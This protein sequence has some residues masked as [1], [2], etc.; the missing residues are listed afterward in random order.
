M[1]DMIGLARQDVSGLIMTSTNPDGR[2]WRSGQP[3]LPVPG[4]WAFG[5]GYRNVTM[6]TAQNQSGKILAR[7]VT[8][9]TPFTVGPNMVVGRGLVVAETPAVVIA[10]TVGQPCRRA[11]PALLGDAAVPAIL[12]C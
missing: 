9:G 3:L 2:P 11:S 12:G 7:L 8:V 4:G 6:L 1:T 10:T 5:G